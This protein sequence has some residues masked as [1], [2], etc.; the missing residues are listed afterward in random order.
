MVIFNFIIVGF[1][2][3]SNYLF[4]KRLKKIES[5]REPKEK[6]KFNIL[7]EK[8]DLLEETIKLVARN[9]LKASKI[10]KE[11]ENVRHEKDSK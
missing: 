10:I 9:P 1:L 6:I 4:S 11:R 8:I 7:N 5:I 3:V 2:C